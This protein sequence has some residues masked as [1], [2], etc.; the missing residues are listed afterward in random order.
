MKNIVNGKCNEKNIVYEC[1]ALNNLE[2][3]AGTM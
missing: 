2:N 3:K 1:Y